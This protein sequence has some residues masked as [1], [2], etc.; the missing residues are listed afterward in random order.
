M[1]RRYMLITIAIIFV[2][3]LFAYRTNVIE[4][5]Y[6]E[7]EMNEET[8]QIL[9]II[10]SM[11]ITVKSPCMNIAQEDEKIYLEG[12]LSILKNEIPF[13]TPGGE[14]KYYEDLWKA[15]IEFDEL[16][17]EKGNKGYPYLYYYDDLD[18]DGKPELAVNQ[19]CLYIFNYE[20]GEDEFTI[21]YSAES[22]YIEKILGAGQIWYHDGLH[23][24]SIRDCYIFLDEK[25]E[26]KKVLQIEEGI[27]PSSPYYEV[28]I[29]NANW[30]DIG[31]KNWNEVI[32]PIKN[33]FKDN[34]IEQLTLEEI[35]GHLLL[36]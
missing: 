33:Y 27:N 3:V 15:G 9:E 29:D 26:W 18:G 1:K 16:L 35:F 28:C 36:E 13:I 17:K 2:G 7:N 4:V 6:K 8:A 23:A 10:Q 14:K 24:N 31:E 22:C 11:D 30:V 5:N 25:N 19:G 32:I 20:L 12:Y 34:G 21:L